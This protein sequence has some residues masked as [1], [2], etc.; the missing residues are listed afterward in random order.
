L[1]KRNLILI[2]LVTI[3]FASCG[4]AKY[5]YN[6]DQGKSL[7]FK[8]GKWILNEPYINYKSKNAYLYA[9]EEF[10]NILGDSLFDLVELR[11]TKIINNQL[12]LDPSKEEL[13]AI[14]E[15]SNCDFLINVESKVLKNEM[16]TMAHTTNIGEVTKY[17]E[18]S[19]TI[20]IY[21]LHNFKKISEATAIGQVKI[22]KKSEDT[23]FFDTFEYT[24]SGG[25]LAIKSIRKLIQKYRK[26]QVE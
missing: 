3:I 25:L 18:A 6:F 24:T 12:P 17:N 10:E 11:K 14:Q 8:K 4:G 16:G 7:N 19:T 23:G 20:K 13:T 1:K 26:Y 9:K 15:F 21:D 2:F 22:T 5:T